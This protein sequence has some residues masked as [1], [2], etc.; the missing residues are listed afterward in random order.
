MPRQ[1]AQHLQRQYDGQDAEW[2]LPN[3]DHPPIQMVADPAA[4]RRAAAARGG[5][6]DREISV[7]LGT[8]LGRRHVTEHHLGARNHA[9][10][11]HALHHA[12]AD[13]HQ[14]AGCRRRDERTRHVDC[15]R[16][17]Q[18]R[19]PAVDIGEFAVK[20]RKRRR[21]DQIR[22]NYPRQLVDVAKDAA[23]GRQR[24]GE[25]RLIDRAEEHRQHHAHDDHPLFAMRERRRI[26]TDE[27]RSGRRD[28]RTD[29]GG[30]IVGGYR[31]PAVVC[32][33]FA[34]LI[35]HEA[36]LRRDRQPRRPRRN[37]DRAI[38]AKSAAVICT[39]GAADAPTRMADPSVRALVPGS[40]IYR[41]RSEVQR[42]R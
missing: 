36:N 40:Q 20:R 7:I 15:E 16:D 1:S 19:A 35:V 28:R 39:L 4:E 14:H 22:R 12:A 21:G 27:R 3:K 24:A 13:Q 34:A 32:G 30:R 33:A 11:A 23:D 26:D 38:T 17:Q 31:L 37:Y 18:R 42:G 2:N 6:C 10:A 41:E 25:D 5:E 8:L 29:Q 9:A